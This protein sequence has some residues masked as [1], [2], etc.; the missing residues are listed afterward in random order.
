MKV[1]DPNEQGATADLREFLAAFFKER[2][3]ESYY[4]EASET[5]S[6]PYITYELRHIGTLDDSDYSRRFI[7]EINGYTDGVIS[8]LDNL[9]DFLEKEFN[10]FIYRGEKFIEVKL[11]YG[12]IDVPEERDIKRKRILFELNYWSKED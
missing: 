9:F 6:F 2:A 3:V 12:R 7:L 1:F 8:Q 11:G 5:A 4:F 10:G